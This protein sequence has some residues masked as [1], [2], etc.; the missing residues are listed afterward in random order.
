VSE[1]TPWWQR[2]LDPQ[3]HAILAS[4]GLVL[5]ILGVV[6]PDRMGA[7]IRSVVFVLAGG[8]LLIN[9]LWKHRQH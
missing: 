8:L 2:R 6:L 7:W 1:K 4:L 5:V 3:Q 9:F